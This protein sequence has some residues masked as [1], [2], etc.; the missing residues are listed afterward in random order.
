MI[1]SS[2][3]LPRKH[4]HLFMTSI[5]LASIFQ[6]SYM[7]QTLSYWNSRSG[8]Q[9][10]QTRFVLIS[11]KNKKK[12][13]KWVVDKIKSCIP[14]QALHVSSF[15]VR[16]C[17]TNYLVGIS[18]STV[19]SPEQLMLKTEQIITLNRKL[20]PINHK[21]LKSWWEM[22][23][24][25]FQVAQSSSV[26]GTKILVFALEPCL[27]TQCQVLSGKYWHLFHWNCMKMTKNVQQWTTAQH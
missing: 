4:T 10:I 22:E 8:L 16:Q 7:W 24:G 15:P 21:S 12:K 2:A 25:M 18:G 23:K 17:C 3:L 11:L 6:K 1:L 19:K 13:R 20:S 14:L 26:S 9:K 5:R 27:Q